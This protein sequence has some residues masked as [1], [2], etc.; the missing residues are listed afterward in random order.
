MPCCKVS[1]QCASA[2]PRRVS[3]AKR[4][5]NV[6]CSNSIYAVLMPPHLAKAPPERLDACRRAIDN[7]ACGLDHPS[8]LVTLDDLG[9]QDMAPWTQSGPSTRARVHG[10]AKGLPHGPDVG[11]RPSVQTTRGRCVAAASHA[12][13]QSSDQRHIACSLTSPPSHKRV[14][15]IIAKAIQTIPPCFLTRISSLAPAGGRAVARRAAPAPPVLGR[16]RHVTAHPATVRS[17]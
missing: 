2:R 16:R 11:L 15:T 6:A 4:S 5:R 12:F 9:D 7:A 1:V 3:D 17:S 10:I 8:P 14:Q 13:D